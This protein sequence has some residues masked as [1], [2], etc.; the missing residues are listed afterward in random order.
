ML[1]RAVIFD[2]AGTIVD[3]GSRAPVV[4]FQKL[5]RE[6]G[7]N[8]TSQEA[9][10][11]MG[12]HKREHIRQILDA[13]SVTERF[14]QAHGRLPK[15]Y[16][17]EMMYN[18]FL[19]FQLDAIRDCKFIPGAE[20]A[21]RDLKSLGIKVGSCTGYSADMM[22][23]LLKLARE[24][25]CMPDCVVTASD[26]AKGRPAPDMIFE[27]CR[28]L[29]V[30]PS[31][32]VVKV[33]DTLLDVQEGVNA[34]VT[35]IGVTDTGNEMGMSLAEFSQTRNLCITNVLRDKIT[36][37]MIAEGADIVIPSVV[38]IVDTLRSLKQA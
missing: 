12:S 22:E 18:A 11:P 13:P 5:F 20:D 9:R 38:N 16:D 14:W 19:H 15:P 6:F 35:S 28:R 3:H 31:K 4:A 7:V 34:G 21:I 10:K 1:T 30:Q 27:A 8:I 29:G 17:V 33:G 25:N 32:Y 26:V 37:K 2:W 24:S 23:P 36:E